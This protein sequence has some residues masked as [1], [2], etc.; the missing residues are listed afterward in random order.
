[1]NRIRVLIADD[2][3][4]FRYGLRALLQ[5]DTEM[6][7]VGEAADGAE[8]VLLAE[9]LAPDVVMMDIGMPQMSGLEAIEVI[10]SRDPQVNILVLSMFD[11]DTVM[12]ALRLGARGYLLKGAGG[13]ETLRAVKAVSE[14]AGVFSPAVASRLT[15]FVRTAEEPAGPPVFPE[16]SDREREILELAAQGF[17]N[18]AIAEKLYLSPK[19]IRNRISEIFDKLQ[20]ADRAEAIIRARQAGMGSALP[21]KSK[22]AR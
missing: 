18:G 4:T 12:S 11:D 22:S 7:V 3:P 20:V 15:E 21:G 13:D 10:L 17:T 5:A 1:M 8:A 6:E 14:G 9:T 16:L 19:T 2:H